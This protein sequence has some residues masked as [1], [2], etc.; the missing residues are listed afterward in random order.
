[1]RKRILEDL[2]INKLYGYYLILCANDHNLLAEIIFQSI[3]KLISLMVFTH[4]IEPRIDCRTK[5]PMKNIVAGSGKAFNWY[6]SFNSN[7]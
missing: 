5:R 4:L 2:I 6:R 7:P 1:M 3:K